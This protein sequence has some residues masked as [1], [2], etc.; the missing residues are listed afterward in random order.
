MK[1]LYKRKIETI[2]VKAIVMKFN[3]DFVRE[4]EQV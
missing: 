4:Q 1:K 3:T 2:E